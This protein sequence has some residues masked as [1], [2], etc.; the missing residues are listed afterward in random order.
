MD[1]RDRRVVYSVVRSFVERAGCE[2]TRW[3]DG[4]TANADN[5]DKVIVIAKQTAM[6]GA[7][8]YFLKHPN[9]FVQF[10]GGS[11]HRKLLDHF[12]YKHGAT[13]PNCD[14]NDPEPV[15]NFCRTTNAREYLNDYFKDAQLMKG[16]GSTED[17]DMALTGLINLLYV[18]QND[19]QSVT[20]GTVR[21]ILHPA[22]DTDCN[23]WP[24]ADYKGKGGFLTFKIPDFVSY[25]WRDLVP[26]SLFQL[27][28]I[29]GVALAPILELPLTFA[30]IYAIIARI[31][32]KDVRKIHETENHVMMIH[33]WNILA[34]HWVM[35]QGRLPSTHPRYD[36]LVKSWHDQYSGDVYNHLDVTK[37]DDYF[38]YN[39]LRFL[40]R[41]VHSGY[42]ETNSK[43][44]S[45][46]ILQPILALAQY[47]NILGADDAVEPFQ[48][49]VKTAA[50]N[51]LNYTAA[52]FAFQSL[53]TKRNAPFRRKKIYR[54]NISFFQNDAAHLM[55]VLSG[56]IEYD[57]CTNKQNKCKVRNYTIAHDAYQ[58]LWAALGRLAAR[59]AN[60][61]QYMYELPEP[62]HGQ[63]F[64][65]TPYF[66]RMQARYGKDNYIK[67]GRD[68][69]YMDTDEDANV[70]GDFVGSP[71]VYFGTD[72]VIL[73]AGGHSIRFPKISE[74]SFR[75]RPTMLFG[76]GDF[77][78]AHNPFFSTVYQFGT[79]NEGDLLDLDQP[80]QNVLLMA[81]E[82]ED[83]EYGASQCNNIVYKNFAYGYQRRANPD[84]SSNFFQGW[85]Q[86]YPAE[87]DAYTSPELEFQVGGAEFK[88]FDFDQGALGS[89]DID[90]ATD[91]DRMRTKPY[92]LILG[93]LQK[94]VAEDPDEPAFHWYQRGT[95]ELIPKNSFTWSSAAALKH[96][97]LIW[98][99][100][101][102]DFPSGGKNLPYHYVLIASKE[103]LTLNSR[104]GS[105]ENGARSCDGGIESIEFTNFQSPDLGWHP[106]DV[107]T[108][109]FPPNQKD[110]ENRRDLPLISVWELNSRYHFTSRKLVEVASHEKDDA[111]HRKGDIEHGHIIVRRPIRKKIEYQIGDEVT[112][113]YEYDAWQCLDINS[114]RWKHPTTTLSES[115]TYEGCFS[116][117]E[118]KLPIT[119]ISAGGSHTCATRAD[120]TA[121]CW[122][123]DGNGRLG[124]GTA[125]FD[126]RRPDKVM[127]QW[128]TGP[129][130]WEVKPFDRAQTISAG[131][132]HTCALQTGGS[133]WCW[134]ANDH[135]QLGDGDPL[136]I[137]KQAPVSVQNPNTS[138][139]EPMNFRMISAGR[140]HTCA[141]SPYIDGGDV[142]D[143]GDRLYCWGENAFGQLGDGT[144]SDQDLP[145]EV[146]LGAPVKLV[147]AGS[148]HTCAITFDGAAY[149]W[150]KNASGQ[151][152]DGTGS[153][154]AF[155]VAVEALTGAELPALEPMISISTGR[156]HSCAVDESFNGWC[157]GNNTSGQLGDG[158][159]ANQYAAKRIPG[160]TSESTV[161]VTAGSDHTCAFTCDFGQGGEC[162]GNVWCWGHNN[163]G[164]IGDG[165][166]LNDRLEPV[167]VM[168]LPHVLGL[169]AGNA[170]SCAIGLDQTLFC[171]GL[172]GLGQLGDDTITNHALPTEVEWP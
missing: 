69:R 14:E 108:Y 67:L 104:I 44:Y 138:E 142:G 81:G 37:G 13:I 83:N 170:H 171:W 156:V 123:H 152:G 5:H 28:V 56:A 153:D 58:D 128:I 162:F 140:D 24:C 18:F 65:R 155:P 11:V 71:E 85:P 98:N 112:L 151:L 8:L 161:A 159:T 66:A 27:G 62:I 19:I 103:R 169:D 143:I 105:A 139:P 21:K 12:K 127:F 48:R 10:D 34:T 144:T 102:S 91:T 154:S 39:I 33:A 129:G 45:K 125:R 60:L 107:N 77:G 36:T 114:H 7:T 136:H 6:I 89:N 113:F 41:I 79:W 133:A 3:G 57:D 82:L 72:D 101:A 99:G 118:E 31:I 30:A 94:A 100:T 2:L 126:S 116:Q 121:W 64:D 46:H 137:Q 145:T 68:A 73:A 88:I 111:F 74:Y 76:L 93:R 35:W 134:G 150:G 49:E 25:K 117:G 95:V 160:L 122:G 23:D 63:M 146:L 59:N 120:G 167:A 1:N 172:N 84:E 75:A 42:F 51:A 131:G 54:K 43:P 22:N 70:S 165:T 55:G 80:A 141:I 16:V 17:Y 135:G 40:G 96:E 50:V 115:L 38:Y 164:Q 157:W 119:S 9:L 109:L 90:P 110:A 86:R 158:F 26:D 78:H 61:T 130:V 47:A 32:G 147:S 53:R 29:L 148:D 124:N 15:Y 168:N 92:F 52:K 163:Y 166:N 20:K 106:R 132:R 4:E 149:C 97:F 87:W